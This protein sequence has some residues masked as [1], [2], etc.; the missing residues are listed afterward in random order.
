VA[1]ALDLVRSWPVHDVAAAV[2]VDGSMVDHEGPIDRP[3]RLASISKPIATWAML[4]AVEEGIVSL[5]DRVGPATLRHLL[6][7][8]AGYG[9]DAAMPIVS[10][11]RK[12]IYSNT[13][14]EVAAEHVAAASEM[15]FEDYLNES[16]LAPLGM[17]HTELHGSPAHGLWSCVTDLA[18]FVREVTRPVLVSKATA[19]LALRPH[20]PALGGIV[21]GV[22]R[23][24]TCPWGLGFEIRGDKTPH[25][26]GAQNS[27]SS[28]GHFGGS[29]TMMWI[30]PS[31]DPV[32]GLV[33]LTDRR[34]DEWSAD[35]LR[36]WPAISDAVIAEF[37]R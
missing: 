37:S 34:F 27:A 9:F 14:I 30:D 33:A 36:L 26:M 13:G 32:I 11:E 5:E 6:A 29:G 3:F 10:P 31:T 19:A 16:V 12:R 22:G 24:D 20:F 35:A 23:F 7:H 17:T 15:K 8:A 4:V 25:W 28:F 21:P 1:R 2:I 18:I